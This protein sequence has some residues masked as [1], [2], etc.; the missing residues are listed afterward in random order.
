VRKAKGK[1][2]GNRYLLHGSFFIDISS[3]PFESKVYRDRGDD[4]GGGG[5]VGKMLC[6]KADTVLGNSLCAN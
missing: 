3:E 5:K 2:L 6:E 4:E 1:T